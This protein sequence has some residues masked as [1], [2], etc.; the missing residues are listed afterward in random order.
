MLL[1]VVTNRKGEYS[2]FFLI[3]LVRSVGQCYNPHHGA[4]PFAFVP[5][6]SAC[7]V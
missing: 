2:T 5:H 7:S 3:A 1:R 6:T 4:T